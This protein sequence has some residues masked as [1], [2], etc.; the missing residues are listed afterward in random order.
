MM[1]EAPATLEEC[2]CLT[3]DPQS[4]RR[5]NLCKSDAFVGH[6]QLAKSESRI[7]GWFLLDTTLSYQYT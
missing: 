6:F 3:L 4:G 2:E 5:W 1:R 7:A